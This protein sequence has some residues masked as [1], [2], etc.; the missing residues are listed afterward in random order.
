MD[1]GFDDSLL[2]LCTTFSPPDETKDNSAL[3]RITDVNAFHK[4]V[5]RRLNEMGFLVSEVI[6]GYCTYNDKVISIETDNFVTDF[7]KE[8]DSTGLFLGEKLGQFIKDTVE[9]DI[10]MN[11][12]EEFLHE[13]EYRFV[14]K[15][16]APF[17]QDKLIIKNL[18]L[19]K[20]CEAVEEK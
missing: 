12:P 19:A 11:K 7:C 5:T 2:V 10:I 9:N 14:W 17:E 8:M 1:I 15:L 16:T 4:E 3:I 13:K 20:Y 6:H 18:D